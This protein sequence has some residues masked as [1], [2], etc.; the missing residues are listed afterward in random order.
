[1]PKDVCFFLTLADAWSYAIPCGG[2]TQEFLKLQEHTKEIIEGL[3]E[4][5]TERTQRTP[6]KSLKPNTKIP[7]GTIIF[8]APNLNGRS[9][10]YLPFGGKICVENCSLNLSSSKTR[11]FLW[12]LLL[13]R[14]ATA[15]KRFVEES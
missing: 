11:A 5:T 15:A 14:F 10:Y 1:V 4:P 8:E 13:S 6:M 2:I 7:V 12:P 9:Y 3:V